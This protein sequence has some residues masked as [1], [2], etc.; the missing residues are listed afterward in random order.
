MVHRREIEQAIR[1]FHWER[2]RLWDCDETLRS[3]DDSRHQWVRDLT[4]EIVNVILIS[5]FRDG[6]RDGHG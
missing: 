4:T 6:L 3:G 2:Y 1:D 5:S